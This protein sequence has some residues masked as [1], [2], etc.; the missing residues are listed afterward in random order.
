MK[1]ILIQPIITEKSLFLASKGVYTFFVDINSGKTSIANAI[2]KQFKVHV[3][4]VKTIIHKSEAIRTGRKRLPD[5]SSI[6]KKAMV[7]LGKDEK[8]DLFTVEQQP[9]KK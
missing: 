2:N 7:T 8:I 5:T 6:W 3:K 4:A 9:A 1:S